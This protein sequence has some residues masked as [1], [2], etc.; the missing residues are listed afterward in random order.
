MKGTAEGLSWWSECIGCRWSSSRP[1]SSKWL[2]SARTLLSSSP[3]DLKEEDLED[4]EVVM[5]GGELGAGLGGKGSA[6]VVES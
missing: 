5:L 6:A 3:R 4:L 1:I 2:T